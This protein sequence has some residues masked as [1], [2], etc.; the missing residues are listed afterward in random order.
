ML[1]K[2]RLKIRDFWAKYKYYIVIGLSIWLIILIVNYMLKYSKK[3]ASPSVSYYPHESIM[4]TKE[5][6]PNSIINSIE[7]W[8][9]S[10]YSACNAKEYETAYNL[11]SEEYRKENTLSNFKE[12]V[13][14]IFNT[15]KIYVLQNYSNQKDIYIYQVKIMDDIMATGLT[16]KDNLEYVIEKVTVKKNG[17]NLEFSIGNKIIQEE[18]NKTY[19]NEHMKVTL[20]KKQTLYDSEIYTIEVENRT[21]YTIVLSDYT[22]LNAISLDIGDTQRDVSVGE[23]DAIIKPETTAYFDFKFT[24]FFDDGRISKALKFKGVR[25]FEEYNGN[26]TEKD[27]LRKYSFSIEL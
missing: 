27:A 8:M 10:F 3:P 2:L 21:D 17:K 24:K 20:V 15:K 5:E 6:V 4:D 11:L 14:D 18:L 19:E 26:E 16:G 12:H 1:L 7:K 9:D 23:L 22:D 13:D 25:I